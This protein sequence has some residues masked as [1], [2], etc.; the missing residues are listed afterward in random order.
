MESTS[1]KPPSLGSLA[2]AARGKQLRRARNILIVVGVL[3]ILVNGIMLALVP[4]QVKSQVNAELSKMRSQRVLSADEQ[5]QLEQVVLRVAFAV[6]G[7][8]VFLGLVFVVFGFLVQRYPVPITVISLVLFIGV[9]V[10]LAVLDPS[11]LVMGWVIKIIFV[12]ALVKALQ[13]AVA[14]QREMRAL[15]PELSHG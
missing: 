12:V 9:H 5:R 15:S 1:D 4:S 10:V 11:T 3:Q 8:L 7:G 13:A 6:T 14:Y 2:Q